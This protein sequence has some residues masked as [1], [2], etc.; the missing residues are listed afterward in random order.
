VARHAVS[1][2]ERRWFF[3]QNLLQP[4]DGQDVKEQWF[5]GV[6]SDVGGGYPEA[7]GGLWRVPFGWVLDEARA[8]GLLV[9]KGRLQQVLGRSSASPAPWDDPRH[10][11]LRGAWWLAE[12][13][14][15][16]VWHPDTKR[17][18]P[19]I[20]RG[21]HRLIRDGDVLHRAVLSRI[22]ETTY[23]PP[24]LSEAFRQRVKRLDAVPDSLPYQA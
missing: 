10:E 14:P 22:R 9:D 20:G 2:D 4:A 13:F 6:H 3:R 5:P 1:V 17:N 11:S 24:N 18:S 8:A 7:D 16:V 21:R 23:A 19:D 12:Y 15:K